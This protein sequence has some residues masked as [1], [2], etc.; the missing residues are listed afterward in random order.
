MSK[1][2]QKTS[3]GCSSVFNGLCLR[4]VVSFVHDFR[5]L[6]ND[7]TFVT[8]KTMKTLSPCFSTLL[9]STF[10]RSEIIRLH[11]TAVKT[12]GR[13]MR[14][15]R[16]TNVSFPSSHRRQ[17]FVPISKRLLDTSTV[18]DGSS[19]GYRLTPRGSGASHTIKVDTK[20]RPPPPSTRFQGNVYLN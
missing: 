16:Q 12:W 19:R 18:A 4:S 13:W 20:R 5:C 1:T 9:P 6:I 15:H 10:R 3:T 11:D 7:R 2:R 17:L 14:Q 8:F